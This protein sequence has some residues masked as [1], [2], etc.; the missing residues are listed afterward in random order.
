VLSFVGAD[1]VISGAAKQILKRGKCLEAG[2]QL[3]AKFGIPPVYP[4]P[5][6]KTVDC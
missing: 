2:I 1:D 5:Y 4:A 6:A 3:K